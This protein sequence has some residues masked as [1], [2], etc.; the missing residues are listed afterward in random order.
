[1]GSAQSLGWHPLFVHPSI[2]RRSCRFNL[3]LCRFRADYRAQ[4][5]VCPGSELVSY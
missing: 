1:M 4:S 3:S 5:V 2:H